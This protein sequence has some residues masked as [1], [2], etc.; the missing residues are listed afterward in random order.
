M[1]DAP[2]PQAAPP[3]VR[4]LDKAAAAPAELPAKAVKAF[5]RIQALV[6]DGYFDVFEAAQGRLDRCAGAVLYAVRNIV[7]T[8]H[9]PA[10]R[11]QFVAE[12][13]LQDV[14]IRAGT[15][16]TDELRASLADLIADYIDQIRRGGG[17]WKPRG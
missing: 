15:A 1:S 3:K 12:K 16:L 6:S 2:A 14:I 4:I 7:N 5:A 17:N 10:E 13:I 11:E 9:I 8:K